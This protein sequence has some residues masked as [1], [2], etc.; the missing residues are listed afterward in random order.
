MI[1]KLLFY[2][3]SLYILKRAYHEV[4][5]LY[6]ELLI[7][8]INNSLAREYYI[9]Y[10]LKFFRK[11]GKLLKVALYKPQILNHEGTF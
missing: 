6:V 4:T 11:L 9:L 7:A 10:N 5:L 3:H 2:P 1:W 8:L